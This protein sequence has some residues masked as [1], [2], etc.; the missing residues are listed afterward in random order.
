MDTIG[1]GN[2]IGSAADPEK[3]RVLIV[4]DEAIIGLFMQKVLQQ[5][6]FIE[7][8]LVS[9][10]TD[11]LERIKKE[12]PNLV[13]MDITIEGPT[14]GIDTAFI[15]KESY[16]IPVIFITGHSDDDVLRKASLAGPYGFIIKPVHVRELY[17]VVETALFK[18][19]MD[20]RLRLSEMKY[21]MLF[22]KS[23]D[24][25]ILYD[26]NR[27]IVDVNFAAIRLFE[28]GREELIGS[29]VGSMVLDPTEKQKLIEHIEASGSIRDVE[30]RIVSKTGREILV[31][32][33]VLPLYGD[34]G[35]RGGYQA[36]VRDITAKRQAEKKVMDAVDMERQRIG[37]DIH[38]GLGQVL[39][40]IGF[41][42]EFLIKKLEEKS[43]PETENA[44]ELLGLVNEARA[45]SRVLARGLNPVNI[46][47][48][49]ILETLRIL[50][51]NVEKLYGISCTL[52][53]EFDLTIE[54]NDRAMNLY[55]IIV[56]AVNNAVRHGMADRIVVDIGH[57]NNNIVV[58]IRDNGIGLDESTGDDNPG[59]LG[60]HIM[61]YRAKLLRAQMEIGPVPGGGTVVKCMLPVSSV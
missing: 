1:Y 10:C 6:G 46:A 58:E 17:A 11:C 43:L 22:E 5:R 44:I 51:V 48:E 13:L 12:P 38:D 24:P 45:Q 42:C 31:S 23:R 15:I 50:C 59:G 29:N 35:Q 28:H 61:R 9:S 27:Q 40:G 30:I 7:T 57:D 8:H 36:F 16:D 2:I 54:G 55:Y 53:C 14:D 20:N 26:N 56:E 47:E 34:N 60:S 52:H 18:H 33:S 41:M 32:V 4:E 19:S 49:G 3:T 21:R 25:I 37:R 39:T